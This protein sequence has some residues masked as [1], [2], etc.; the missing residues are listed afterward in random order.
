MHENPSV[1]TTLQK[2]PYEAW[3]LKN[4]SLW[5]DFL[6]HDFS[7]TWFVFMIAILEIFLP[8]HTWN[9]IISSKPC[10]VTIKTEINQTLVS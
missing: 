10:F 4:T 6:L 1:P 5:D 9:I 7:L 3:V 2:D 8:N